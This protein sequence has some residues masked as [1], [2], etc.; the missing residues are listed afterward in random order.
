MI[1]L[2]LD[3]AR[4]ERRDNYP[5]DPWATSK[6]PRQ[7]S[8]RAPAI[9]GSRDQSHATL[10]A[11]THQTVTRARDSMSARP[12]A[13]PTFPCHT[14]DRNLATNRTL[15]D[16]IIYPSIDSASPSLLTRRTQSDR[17]P[18]SITNAATTPNPLPYGAQKRLGQRIAYTCGREITA[19]FHGLTATVPYSTLPVKALGAQG[20]GTSPP[21]PRTTLHSHLL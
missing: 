1:S 14:T 18:H 10:T 7:A 3:T 6:S 20:R 9:A 4:S 12:V 19:P 5:A 13:A 17:A 8:M 15:H 21:N 2:A 16:T 11:F